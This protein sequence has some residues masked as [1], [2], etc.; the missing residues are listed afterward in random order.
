MSLVLNNQAQLF[1]A[2]LE[3]HSHLARICQVLKYIWNQVFQY[4]LLKKKCP[5]KC[6]LPKTFLGAFSIF[7]AKKNQNKT[8][9]NKKKIAVFFSK[10]ITIALL[11]FEQLYPE[12]LHKRILF[13]QAI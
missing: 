2:S 12:S 8:K 11:F 6:F 9:Q 4:I 10:S 1:K 7:L 3:E 5:E 13:D